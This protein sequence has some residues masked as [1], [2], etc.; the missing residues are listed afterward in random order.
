MGTRHETA[1]V[2]SPTLKTTNLILTQALFK[3]NPNS[4]PSPNSN[5]NPNPNPNH[6]LKSNF[7]ELGA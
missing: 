4:N 1:L 2:N 3:P 5:P 7:F 6:L